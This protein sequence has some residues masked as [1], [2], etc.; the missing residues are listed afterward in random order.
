MT[1]SRIP[2]VNLMSFLEKNFSIHDFT[3]QDMS[4][5]RS[6]MP[7]LLSENVNFYSFNKYLLSLLMEPIDQWAPANKDTAWGK[8]L[9]PSCPS[10]R[11]LAVR[12][13]PGGCSVDSLHL[14]VFSLES[15]FPL[16]FC[17]D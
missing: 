8:S 9:A 16:M 1:G 17:S 5:I 6:C 2:K 13:E 15:Q 3:H 7:V 14:H 12:G 10:P 11:R 4:L